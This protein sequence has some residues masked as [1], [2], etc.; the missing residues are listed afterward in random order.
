MGKTNIKYGLERKIAQALGE[1][2]AAQKEI[3]QIQAGLKRL[4]ALREKVREQQALLSAAETILKIEEPNWSRDHIKPMRKG[5]WSSPFAAGDL[6]LTALA[7]LREAGDWL[8]AREI[9]ARML[10]QIGH[11]PD[12]KDVLDRTANSVTT[13]LKKYEGELVESR[14]EYPKEWR[15]IR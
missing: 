6:G 10:S 2:E 15:V 11:D 9:A 5:T 1:L 4:I 13:Y 12:D 3:N 8:R 14:R 7:V